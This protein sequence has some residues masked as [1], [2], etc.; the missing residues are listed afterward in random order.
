[1]K[2]KMNHLPGAVLSLLDIVI[3]TSRSVFASA[4]GAR[5]L[6]AVAAGAFLTLGYMSETFGGTL[7]CTCAWMVADKTTYLLTAQLTTSQ[8]QVLHAK[9]FNELPATARPLYLQSVAYAVGIMIG[10]NALPST[11]ALTDYLQT[12]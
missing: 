10:S 7:K 6:L 2:T 5:R 1:M 8:R 11:A 9:N 4:V 3:H 12:V